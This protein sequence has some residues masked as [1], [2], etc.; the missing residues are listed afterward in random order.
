MA[1]YGLNKKQ[2]VM[3]YIAGGILFYLVF[4]F[5]PFQTMDIQCVTTP[6]N[7]IQITL[8]QAILESF[9]PEPI[10]CVEI[11]A[12]VCGSDAITYSNS[13]FAEANGVEVIHQGMCTE[14]DIPEE[15]SIFEQIYG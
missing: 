1:L 3:L 6:C 11:F 9:E 4:F 10:A 14:Q 15:K 7:P 8:V 12:P 2:L 5:I 13:C